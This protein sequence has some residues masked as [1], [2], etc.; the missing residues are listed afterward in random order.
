M[1]TGYSSN[2]PSA[3]LAEAMDRLW[4]RFLPEIVERIGLM[5]AAAE[6]LADGA[7]SVE[8]C[9]AAH[10][11]AHKLA[12]V[13]GSFNLARGTELAREAELMLACG[14]GLEIGAAQRLSEIAS[15]LRLLTSSRISA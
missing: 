8:Q 14:D 4:I 3:A 6:S 13:L 15:E 2:A 10:A 7:L 12:G 9:E 1:D 5:A 11:A